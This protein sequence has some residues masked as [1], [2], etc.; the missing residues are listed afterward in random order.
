M[1]VFRDKRNKRQR[2]LEKKTGLERQRYKEWMEMGV[3]KRSQVAF[4][5]F[6]RRKEKEWMKNQDQHVGLA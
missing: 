6:G 3:L 4:K 5:D 1:T 2:F